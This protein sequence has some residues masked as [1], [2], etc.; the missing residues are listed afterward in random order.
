VPNSEVPENGRPN[1][2]MSEPSTAAS[3]SSTTEADPDIVNRRLRDDLASIASEYPRF[4]RI[5]RLI[6]SVVGLL[7]V[8]LAVTLGRDGSLVDF[9]FHLPQLPQLRPTVLGAITFLTALSISWYCVIK[10]AKLKYQWEFRKQLL[11]QRFDVDLPSQPGVNVTLTT[12]EG[13][14]NFVA[15]ISSDAVPTNSQPIPASPASK[16]AS[17]NES[18]AA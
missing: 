17:S 7:G 2:L 3:D 12:T 9:T 10:M 1:G 8:V 16:H 4:V 15:K 5:V 11:Q 18:P 14:G 6:L 13:G